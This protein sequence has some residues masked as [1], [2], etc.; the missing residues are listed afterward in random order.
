MN[1]FV[2]MCD[3]DCVTKMSDEDDEE[4]LCASVPCNSINFTAP[5]VENIPADHSTQ[6]ISL[7]T[8][9]KVR[10]IPMKIVALITPLKMRL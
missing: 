5:S 7:N 1:G 9:L 2:T 3:L 10:I 6:F 8:Q 4:N